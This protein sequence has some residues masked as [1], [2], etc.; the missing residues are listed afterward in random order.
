MGPPPL[1]RLADVARALRDADPTLLDSRHL[2][3]AA[4]ERQVL[5]DGHG[6]PRQAD[7]DAAVAAAYLTRRRP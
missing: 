6:P 7:L 5:S 3:R 2:F 4:V 1:E